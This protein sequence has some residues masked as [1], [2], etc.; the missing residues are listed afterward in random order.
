MSL[1]LRLLL[2]K[3]YLTLSGSFQQLEEF[4]FHCYQ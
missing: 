1:L 2:L 4:S 3:E